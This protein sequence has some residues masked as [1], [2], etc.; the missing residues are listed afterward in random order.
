MKKKMF[1]FV[2][3]LVAM[4]ALSVPAMAEEPV[5]VVVYGEQLK[6]DVQ[7]VSI[8]G[9]TLV[10][11]RSIFE[12]LGIQV[13]WNNTTKTATG[14]RDDLKITLQLNNKN[15]TV[16]GKQVVLRVAATS[17]GGKTMVPLRFIGE[18]TGAAVHWEGTTRTAIITSQKGKDADPKNLIKSVEFATK[19][20][21]LIDSDVEAA[22][23]NFDLALQ[24]DPNNVVALVWKSV[25][26]ERAGK[27]EAAY[28]ALEQALEVFPQSAAV[29][30]SKASL[31]LRLYYAHEEAL[32]ALEKALKYDTAK[33]LTYLIHF[34]KAA[35]YNDMGEYTQAIESA[36]QTIQ[37]KAD[38]SDAYRERGIYYFNMGKSEEALKDINKALL[39]NAKDSKAYC[40]RGEVYYSLGKFDQALASYEKAQKYDPRN[41]NVYIGKGRL[42]ELDEEYDKAIEYYD[43]AI[44]YA[45]DLPTPYFRKAFMMYY[46]GEL[47][48]CEDLLA[49]FENMPGAW[50]KDEYYNLKGN[51]SFSNAEY[52]EAVGYYQKAIELRDDDPV[53]YSNIAFTYYY[54]EEYKKALANYDKSLALDPDNL[55]VYADKARVYMAQENY[56]KAIEVCDLALE[57][58]V[59]P[60]ALIYNIKGDALY[61]AGE[62][63]K[64]VEIYNQAIKVDP[65]YPYSYS[66]LGYIYFEF[67]LYEEA[68]AY[69]DSAIQ[70]DPEMADAYFTKSMIYATQYKKD[71]CYESLKKAI[72]LDEDYREIAKE[73]DLLAAYS[74]LPEFSQLLN[75]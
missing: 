51:I 47:E 40:Y 12:A 19:G 43:M 17:V 66:S 11:L 10:P 33:Q 68:L 35:V 48:E 59:E 58:D 30:V 37:L 16:N 50:M 60:T 9:T 15:A 3:M 42:A 13:D 75:P 73:I 61:W 18:S 21:A 57:R 64:A 55:D 72:E 6:L 70:L 56:Q 52:T 1:I 44:S 29:L 27:L 7:P 39:M 65:Y 23:K 34:V 31:E 14:T 38:F 49:K 20:I 74:S 2:A 71:E 25:A 5:K 22:S 53:Y 45:P 41:P 67:E 32:S 62:E 24:A 36:T 26:S 8:D 28:K 46:R 69:L 63:E 54:L 4:L